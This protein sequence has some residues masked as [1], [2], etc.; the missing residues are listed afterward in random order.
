MRS[1]CHQ[2][3]R[4]G[5]L[6]DF[7]VWPL[8]YVQERTLAQGEVDDWWVE[9]L[10]ARQKTCIFGVFNILYVLRIP[11]ISCHENHFS[12]Y[13]VNPMSLS[14]IGRKRLRSGFM[15]LVL[16]SSILASMSVAQGA[17]LK[18]IAMSNADDS[19]LLYL[20]VTDCFSGEM[21]QAIDNGIHTTFTFYIKV[22]EVKNFWVDKEIADL[23]V[24][25]EIQYDNLKKVY[26]VRLSEK[27]DRPV[28]VETF[29]EAKDLIAKL[30][31]LNV[32]KLDNLY[33]GRHY[34]VRMM[35]ELD[36]IRLPFH[37]H[38]I[39]FFLSLWDFKTDWYTL[40]FTY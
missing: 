16:I 39:F 7:K 6:A 24:N 15:A 2:F 12:L 14:S 23:E 31:R 3:V 33:K 11:C 40:D 38:Y 18:D 34:K 10:L 36:R 9:G 20:T 5:L 37:L 19:L 21:R 26:I 30:V 29:D 28:Y 8:K 25:H 4:N 27:G 13:R 22:F 35:A 32:T 17:A 1:N